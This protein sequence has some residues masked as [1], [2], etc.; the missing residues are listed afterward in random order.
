MN[1]AVTPAV[2]PAGLW[3]R[4]ERVVLAA[5]LVAGA[6]LVLVAYR[7]TGDDP[8]GTAQVAWLN[9]GVIGVVASAFGGS[10]WIRGGRRALRRRRT[11]LLAGLAPVTAGPAEVLMIDT[12]GDGSLVVTG[13]CRRYH[14]P[15]CV[16]VA[17]RPTS[18]AAR[19]D[20]EAIGRQACEVCRP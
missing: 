12:P 15:A 11:A 16:L 17:G 9:T 18:V 8:G 1:R 13:N 2:I 6:V 20:H 7:Q 3:R 10:L 14:R 4:Q 5:G 19:A